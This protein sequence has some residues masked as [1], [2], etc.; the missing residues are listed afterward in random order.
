MFFLNRQVEQEAYSLP[1]I[2]E[3]IESMEGNKV[4]SVI[5]LKDG[6]FHI[7]LAEEDRHKTAFRIGNRLYEWKFLPQGFTN[8]FN[9]SK[10]YG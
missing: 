7:P 5:D 10:S 9:I 2:Q 6:Y 3:V 4:L 8:A 1:K